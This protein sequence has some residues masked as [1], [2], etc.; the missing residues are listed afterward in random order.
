MEDIKLMVTAKWYG[1]ECYVTI[2]QQPGR[3][4]VALVLSN[5]QQI[6]QLVDA[7]VVAANSK[8]EETTDAK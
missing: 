2:G 7:L 3:I 1:S 6:A 4:T 5:T 8:P